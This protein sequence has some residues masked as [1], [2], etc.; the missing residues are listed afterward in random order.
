MEFRI[1]GPVELVVEGRVTPLNAA[2][3]RALLAMLFLNANKPLSSAR[4]IDDLWAG[5]PPATAAKVLQAYVSQLRRLIGSE[6]IA[7]GP[8]GYALSVGPGELD[9]HRFE[10]LVSAAAGAD[11]AA[12]ASRLRQALAL[13]RGPPLVDFAYEPWA[14][15]EIGRLNELY[16]VALQARIDADLALG[17]TAELVG[18]LELLVAEHPLQESLHGQLMLALYRSN[19]QAE[20]LEVYRQARQTLVAQLGIEP[21]PALRRLETDILRQDPRLDLPAPQPAEAR[22]AQPV[23]TLPPRSTS[24]VGRHRELLEIRKLLASP[25]IRLLTLTGPAGTGKTRLAV[26]AA[27]GLEAE[28]PDGVVLVELAPISDPDLVATTI[29]E[30]LALGETHGRRPT[31]AL[32]AYLQRRRVLLILDNFEQLLPAAPVVTELLAGAQQVKILVTSRAPL[33]LGEEHIQAVPAL[34]LPDPTS[35]GDVERLRRTEAVSLFVDR[36]RS[37][38]PEF[39]VSTAN[40]AAVAE[41]CLRLDALPLALELAAARVKVLS[42][43]AILDRVG[44]SLEL[45][46]A[47]PGAALPERHRTLRAAIAWSYALLTAD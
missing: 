47:Q 27:A 21:G 42:V 24:F 32:I 2:K 38:R 5:R 8:N 18:E 7:T 33:E 30:T 28:F 34:R 1:L 22:Q 14:Q 43:D 44:R 23:P 19:R 17:V 13:W 16:L 35:L 20:A 39:E 31:E 4:L 41:L 25:D 46:K 15:L 11:P 36:A 45:L 40:A 3:P 9:L 6:V 12:A 10:R 37:V 29:A 26:E